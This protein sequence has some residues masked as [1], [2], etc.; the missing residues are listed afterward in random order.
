MCEILCVAE[1][2][3]KIPWVEM[4]KSHLRNVMATRDSIT[5]G[6]EIQPRA[7]PTGEAGPGF[8]A[9]TAESNSSSGWGRGSGRGR[10]S[11]NTALPECLF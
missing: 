7:R 1:I 3:G 8:E 10:S 4:P 5:D 6:G 11:I 2:K 9:S